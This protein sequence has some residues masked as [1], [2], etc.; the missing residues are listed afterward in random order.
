MWWFGRHVLALPLAAVAPLSVGTSL[1]AARRLSRGHL[2][3]ILGLFVVT[4]LASNVAV[5]LA[6]AAGSLV[7]LII[8]PERFRPIFGTGPWKGAAGPEVQLVTTIV[9][10]LLT[11]PLVTLTFSVVAFALVSEARDPLALRLD[12]SHSDR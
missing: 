1:R 5:L 4:A 9:A 8:V 10:S 12:P 3:T 11:L 2:G 6:R 7:T